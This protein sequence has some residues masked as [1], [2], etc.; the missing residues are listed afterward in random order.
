MRWRVLLTTIS[1]VA[2]GLAFPP[3]DLRLLAWVALAPLL[4]ALPD[5]G[6]RE[7]FFL[8]W[9]WS[10]L[11]AYVV[12]D[13]MPRSVSEYYLQPFWVG[14][15]VFAGIS[16]A[17]AALYYVAFGYAY[18]RLEPRFDRAL[19][20]LV[21]AAWTAAELGR[22]RLFTGTPFFVGNPWALLG[23][24]QVPALERVQ[25]AAW[26]GVYGVSF[27]LVCTSA[28]LAQAWR[29]RRSWTARRTAARLAAAAL[30][31]VGMVAYGS[32]VLARAPAPG[33]TSAGVEVA[34]VQGDVEVGSRWR[35][36]LYGKNLE[37]YLR[38]THEAA[39]AGAPRVAFW[40][41]ASMTFFVE[42]EPLYRAALGRLLGHHD[43]ELVAGAPRTVG[44][45]PERFTN[46][47]Y[48]VAPTG[49]LVGRYDKEMLVPFAEYFPFAGIDVLRRS[50]GRIREFDPGERTEPLATRAGRAGVA[51]C[52]EAM[53]PEVVGARVAAG[54]EY[55]V[56]PSNDTWIADEKFTAQQFHIVS[57]RAVEQRRW[58]VRA[59]T[60]GP[61]ALVDPW[62][63]VVARA[64]PGASAFLLGRIEPRR[65]RTVFGRVGDAFAFGCLA[66]VAL[67][68]LLTRP[69]AAP[70]G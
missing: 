33:A 15:A 65:D 35:S 70:P 23:Y 43:L 10:V 41:E 29:H 61:S 58:L 52:N 18:R 13:W 27:A 22:G 37:T 44:G 54:A 34:V 53:L 21:A 11:M 50:F 19:P 64:E 14:V 6:R 24:S 40:P 38:L 39:Q 25:V 47:I 36:D 1:A 46:S 49:E 12:G 59:S 42:D 31:T 66:V 55:L 8:L 32:F 3:Y 16:S 4:V 69:R 57:L 67:A 7:T 48:R 5:A 28:A 56:N 20:F 60:S 30:P 51:V 63:R 45:E 62:G 17:T 9:G 2:F 26:T 68:L